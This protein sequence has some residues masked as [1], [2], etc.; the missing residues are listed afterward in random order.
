MVGHFEGQFGKWCNC[1]I[2]RYC[3]RCG[4]GFCLL[5]R[6]AD[7][8][9]SLPRRKVKAEAMVVDISLVEGIG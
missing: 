5:R 3:E 1:Q 4:E 6:C 2:F 9:K 8:L 7:G